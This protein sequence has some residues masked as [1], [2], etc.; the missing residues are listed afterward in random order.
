MRRTSAVDQGVLVR[1]IA[2]L[3]AVWVWTDA[4]FLRQSHAAMHDLVG[5]VCA[6]RALRRLALTSLVITLLLIVGALAARALA[7]VATAR[8]LAPA[9]PATSA[10]TAA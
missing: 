1:V 9:A 5:V 10:A 3:R 2:C 7:L 6:P 4:C 8:A